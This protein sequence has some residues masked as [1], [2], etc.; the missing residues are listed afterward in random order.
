[1]SEKC[2]KCKSNTS[3]MM[4]CKQCKFQACRKCWNNGSMCPVCRNY[5]GNKKIE[6]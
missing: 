6:V 4:Q 2:P 3:E 1:M 5:S